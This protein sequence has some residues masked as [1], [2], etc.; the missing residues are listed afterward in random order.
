M[1]AVLVCCFYRQWP[2]VLLSGGDLMGSSHAGLQKHFAMLCG[3]PQHWYTLHF[4][5][6]SSVY[7]VGL[8][9]LPPYCSPEVSVPF[10]NRLDKTWFVHTTDIS[11]H[12]PKHTPWMLPL[13]HFGQVNR[14]AICTKS[15]WRFFFFFSFFFFNNYFLI[16]NLII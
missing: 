10:C 13:S 12:D 6:V 1:T 16:L 4:A 3:E 9:Q 5:W 15:V 2:R 7:G 8:L 14:K 11:D